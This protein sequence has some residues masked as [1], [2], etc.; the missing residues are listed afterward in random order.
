MAKPLIALPF[1]TALS[2]RLNLPAGILRFFPAAS[3]FSTLHTYCWQCGLDFAFYFFPFLL[4][5][6]S[7]S[8]VK[9][10][11]MLFF[12]SCAFANHH[13]CKEF[14]IPGLDNLR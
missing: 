11:P 4:T 7:R 5:F 8:V 10:L 1:I 6:T 9:S 2:E 14:F 3:G 12:F 13:V